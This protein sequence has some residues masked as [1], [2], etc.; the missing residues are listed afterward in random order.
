MERHHSEDEVRS[1]KQ[2]VELE[3]LLAARAL[4]I[5]NFDIF[6]LEVRVRRSLIAKVMRLFDAVDA[7]RKL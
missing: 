5:S 3:L 6:D 7:V 4:G 2:R 1:E